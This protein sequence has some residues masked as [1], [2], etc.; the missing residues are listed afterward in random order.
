MISEAAQSRDNLGQ[1]RIGRA[2]KRAVQ[3]KTAALMPYFTLGYPDLEESLK[4]IKAIAPHSDLLELGVPFSDPIADGPTIQRSTQQALDQGMNTTLCLRSVRRLREA[5]VET[6]VMLMGYYNPILAYGESRYVHDAADAGVD[7]FII[8]DLPPEEA[9]ALKATADE[10]G[11]ALVYFLAPTSNRRRIEL[12]IAGARGFIYMVSVTGVTG[13]RNKLSGDLARL[14]TQVRSQ[15]D[16]PV[17]V[18]FGIGTP[19]QAAEVA[20]YADGV[21]VGSALIDAVDQ[22]TDKPGAAAAFVRSLETSLKLD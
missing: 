12:V 17:A 8:P 6:P 16:L 5:G 7:G 3:T 11:L 13:A 18:G 9:T 21:I 10:R 14:V 20:E 19:E 22:A 1:Q 2:F 4:I 15:S